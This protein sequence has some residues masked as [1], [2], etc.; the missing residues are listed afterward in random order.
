M[1]SPP[2][3]SPHW[4]DGV[5]PLFPTKVWGMSRSTCLTDYRRSAGIG[6]QLSHETT[7]EEK[8]VKT[9]HPA[10]ADKGVKGSPQ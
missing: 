2:A 1:T 7:Y 4:P 10:V 3:C 8:K 5:A 6:G 9:K